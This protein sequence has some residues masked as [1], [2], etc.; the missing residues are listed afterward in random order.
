MK[1][2]LELLSD[3]LISRKKSLE[4]LNKSFK[5]YS[6]A[7][8]KIKKYDDRLNTHNFNEFCEF[9][10]DPSSVQSEYKLKK[11]LIRYFENQYRY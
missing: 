2:S 4:V 10:D 3:E 8:L 1:H 11:A 9:F 6:E 7:I 5:Y